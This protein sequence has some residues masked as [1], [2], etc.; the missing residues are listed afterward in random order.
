MDEA[1][2]VTLSSL[3]PQVDATLTATLSDP[4]GSPSDVTWLWESSLDRNTWA[5][6]SR[7]DSAYYTPADGDLDK[8]L[9]AMASY[10]DPEGLGKSARSESTNPVRAAVPINTAPAFTEDTTTRTVEENTVAATDIGEPVTATDSENAGLTYSL[11]GADADSFSIVP[12]SGQLQTKASLNYEAAKNSHSVI[13]QA[14]DG[15]SHGTVVVTVTVTDIDEPPSKPEAPTV[16]PASTSGHNTLAVTWSAPANTGPEITGYEAEYRKQGAEGWST[17]NVTVSGTDAAITGVLPDTNYEAR[18]R[19]TN[20]EGTGQWSGPG[21]GR[22]G[23][24]P[25]NLQIELTVNYQADTYTVN[26]GDSVSVTVT[27]STAADRT[28]GV[29][30]AITR[31]TAEAGDYE[32]SGLSGGALAFSPGAGSRNFTIQ[33][34]QDTDSSDETVDLGFGQLPGKVMTGSTQTARVTINDD[35]STNREPVFAEGSSALRWVAENTVAATDIGE[36]VTA[37]DSE[38][39]GLTYSLS[40]ADADSFSIVPSSG[41]LQ[42]KASLN[43]EAAK[44]SHSV[45]VQAWDGS[46]HGTVVVTITVTDIDEPPSKPEAP[47]VGPASTSGHNTLAVTWSAPANTGPEITGYEAEYRK[48]GAEGWSTANVTVSGTEAAITGV[49]PDTNYEARVRATNDE[50]TGQWSGPGTGRSGVTPDNLQIELTV[51]YQADTYTVNEGDSASVTVTLSTAADRTVRVPIAITRGTAEAGDYEVSGLSG[52]A[53]AFSPGA[54]SRNF[55]IQA[56]QDTDSSDE[57]VDLGFGQLPGKV[58]TGST[59]TARVTINDDD[60]VNRVGSGN[61]NP[62]GVGKSSSN[63]ST[64]VNRAPVFAEGDS[65]ARSVEENTAAGTGIGDPVAATDADK[66]SLAYTLGGV[67]GPYFSLVGTSGQL[68]TRAA[69]DYEARSSYTVTVGVSDG[70]GGNDSIVVTITVTDVNRTPP[71]TRET[72]V[73]ATINPE[74]ETTVT[75]PQVDV[76][77]KFPPGSRETKYQVRID[78][79]WDNCAG[80]SEEEGFQVC[81]TVEFFD[82]DGN[83][84]QDVVLDQPAAIQITL[85]SGKVGGMDAMLAVYVLG[86]ISVHTRSGVDSDWTEVEFTMEAD[87]QGNAIITVTGIRRF[88][89]FTVGADPWILAHVLRM[90]ASAPTLTPIPEPTLVPTVVP[91]PQATPVPTAV[92]AATAIQPTPQAFFRLPEHLRSNRP[93]RSCTKT[94]PTHPNRRLRMV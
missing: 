46:S 25:D 89:D 12:S 42:T 66:D 52:G 43:Y 82:M 90:L 34:V 39:A 54:G 77:V 51:N 85:G 74:E 58:M 87:S 9:R 70:K 29:P 40:G 79:A 78:S 33:A 72:Q 92:P 11:S 36:P 35:S 55:T 21:T 32:V 23:V 7:A 37:T 75:L 80:D 93:K 59:Q 41:Q 60:P 69:L 94:R 10:A 6:I 5:T 56:V 1:G 57:T 50:G 8:N 24:T 73:V 44:N 88:S 31:G 65:T 17:A 27:L 53:L 38:N 64:P 62:G 28:V 13:V 71:V 91:Q 45:I 3:Q 61:G 67:D 26:E 84:E 15:S 14:S 49:L 20:D 86:G 4:D 63:S 22:S 83:P 47:T 30:I 76:A 2:T 81:L 68:M 19:A 48:Q 16:G 18:V